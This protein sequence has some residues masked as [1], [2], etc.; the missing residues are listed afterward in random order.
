MCPSPETS[1]G[2]EDLSFSPAKR[3]SDAPEASE[4][5]STPKRLGKHWRPVLFAI[6]FIALAIA[7]WIL[8]LDEWLTD[9]DLLESM[10]QQAEQNPGL[11]LLLYFAGT[12]VGSVALALPGI[13]FALI[14]GALF[15]PYLGTLYCTMAATAGAMLSFQAARHFLDEPVRA[16][17]EK[18]PQIKKWLLDAPRDNAVMLLL[19]TRMIP[20]FPYNLQNFAYGVT[21]IPFSTYSVCTFIFMIPGTALYTFA[22]AGLMDEANRLPYLT[23]AAIIAIV[24][25]ATARILKKHFSI[26]P[27]RNDS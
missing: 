14:A 15:G 11:V 22:A 26:N 27:V 17:A 25:F 18:H 2:S 6:T 19:I 3:C 4:T 12:V 7:A 24:V 16:A 13:V 5:P 9:A 1:H 20:V 10:H 21:S 8:G 23:A